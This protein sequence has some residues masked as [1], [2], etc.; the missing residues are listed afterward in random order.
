MIGPATDMERDVSVG[1]AFNDHNDDRRTVSYAGSPCKAT[2]SKSG[3][4]FF[5]APFNST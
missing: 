5:D 1:N 2:F 3:L 4:V